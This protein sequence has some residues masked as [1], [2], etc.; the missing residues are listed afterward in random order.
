MEEEFIDVFDENM[1]KVGV[2]DRNEAHAKGAWHKTFH[3]WIVSGLNDGNVLFQKRGR[4]KKL[5][6]NYLDITAAGHYVSGEDAKDGLREILEELGLSV[7]FSDLIPL[8]KKFDIAKVGNIINREFCD[9]F[10]LRKDLKPDEFNPDPEEVEG[11]VAMDI[12]S[13]L[14]LFK[15]EVGKAKVEGIEWDMEKKVWNMITMDIG[16]DT[17]IPRIDPYYYKI[18]IMAK[19]LLNGEKYLSI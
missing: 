2:M 9:V 17:I 16:T 18:F 10:L 3:C 15:G 4:H 1:T 14:A 8:G 5:F 13:G 11:L 7:S 19:G 12:D 6:P